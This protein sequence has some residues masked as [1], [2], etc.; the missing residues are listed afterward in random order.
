MKKDCYETYMWTW[1]IKLKQNWAIIPI[2]HASWNRCNMA[3]MQ[4]LGKEKL[5]MSQEAH[6]H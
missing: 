4:Q 1:V 6:G 2:S 5:L 3:L